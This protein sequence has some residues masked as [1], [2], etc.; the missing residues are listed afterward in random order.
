MK[1]AKFWRLCVAYLV[2]IIVCQIM[3]FIVG[4][5]TGGIVGFVLGA[6][7]LYTPDNMLLFTTL[8]G[9]AGGLAGSVFSIL[10]FASCEAYWG[11]TLG[12][13]LMG[14]TVVQAAPKTQPGE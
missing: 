8:T 13:K 10:Y 14:L 6:A 12:K 2:D 5:I 4:G 9:L 1:K 11:K 7:G 3:G